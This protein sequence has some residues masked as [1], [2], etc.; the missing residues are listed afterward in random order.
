[1]QRTQNARQFIKICKLKNSTPF[2]FEATVDTFYAVKGCVYLLD[3]ITR[4]IET[5]IRDLVD[6]RPQN[7][8][9]SNNF[10]NRISRAQRIK[11]HKLSF[12]SKIL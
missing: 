9:P 2:G 7:D 1:M 3:Q 4:S 12:I 10:F 8:S 6:G 11:K 5:T